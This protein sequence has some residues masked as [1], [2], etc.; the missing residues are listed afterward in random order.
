M[1][2]SRVS[3]TRMPKNL[4]YVSKDSSQVAKNVSYIS[5]SRR[6]A[7]GLRNNRHNVRHTKTEA[8]S[9]SS[10]SSPKAAFKRQEIRIPNFDISSS[11][12]SESSFSSSPVLHVS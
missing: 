1:Q 12:E 2:S 9:T 3:N 8:S 10:T 6:K 5:S 7:S 4:E 11:Q